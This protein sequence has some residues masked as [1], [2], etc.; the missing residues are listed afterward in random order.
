[1]TRIIACVSG[2]GGAGKTTIVS[3]LGAALSKLGK[4]VIV[5][6]TNVTTPNLGMHLGLPTYPVTLHDALKGKAS[7]REAVYRHES[8][9][10]VVPAGIAL[11][12]L[13]G[14][15]P[16]NLPTLLLDLLGDADII[17]L[18]VAAGLGKEALSAMEA[19]DETLIVTNPEL[20]SAADALKAAKIAQQLGSR[21]LG[22]VVNRYT[23]K[24]YEMR[25]QDVI[26]MIGD[27]ELMGIVPEDV[28]VKK[29]IHRKTP[30]VSFMP[31]SA[32]SVEIRKIA[33]SIAGINYYESQ[34]WYRRLF[35]GRRRW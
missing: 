27:H 9:M 35:F 19:A 33:A 14:A 10:G 20:T 7:I 17:L 12:D 30:V 13:R 4:K 34:P 18:D 16:G 3:N 24:E 29:S 22:V 26:S 5:L 31:K 21:I 32:A 11:R 6:D 8:G 2:K 25:I 28:N 1:M 23:G 15:D